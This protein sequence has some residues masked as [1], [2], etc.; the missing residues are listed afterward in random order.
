PTY[1]FFQRLVLT[2]EVSI[3]PGLCIC[4]QPARNEATPLSIAIDPLEGLEVNTPRWPPS[5]RV[6]PP[7]FNVVLWVP[8]GTCRG[9]VPLT[10]AAAL[11]G[12]DHMVGVTVR[13][14]ACDDASCLDPSSV[15]LRVPVREAALI[16]RSLPSSIS[17][18]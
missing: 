10:F 3:D 12:G 2:G 16:G 18:T 1:V 14:Q 17:R 15:Q 9:P 11:G 4:A 5:R 8:A 13:F 7:G 6:A